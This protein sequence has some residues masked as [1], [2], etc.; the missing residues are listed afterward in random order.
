MI[1]IFLSSAAENLSTCITAQLTLLHGLRNSLEDIVIGMA[2]DGRSPGSDVVNV[3]VF[4]DVPSVGALD[5]VEDD[6]VAADG[7]EGTDGRGDSTGHELQRRWGVVEIH[8]DFFCENGM[9][10]AACLSANEY[11]QSKR[12]IAESSSFNCRHAWHM[13]EHYAT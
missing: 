13:L 4:I 1:L 11:H 6:G 9:F 12:N 7:L 10:W 5:A 3:L 8:T 2:E